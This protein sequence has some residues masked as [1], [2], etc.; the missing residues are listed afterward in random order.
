VTYLSE[1]TEEERLEHKAAPDK[2]GPVSE[3]EGKKRHNK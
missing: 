1:A 2:V 3:K